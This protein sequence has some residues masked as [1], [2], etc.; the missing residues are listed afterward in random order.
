MK[1]PLPIIVASQF[2][3]TSLWFAGNAVIP[4][5]AKDLHLEDSFVAHITSSVQFGFISGTFIF[6]FLSIADRFSPS[7]VFFIS[8]ILAS[9]FN[10][11]ACLNGIGV[12]SLLVL[13]FLTGFFLAGIY[14]V[15]MKIASDY[16]KGNL[17]RSLGFLLAALVLGTAFPHLLKSLGSSL[18]WK[19]VLASTSLF[20][21]LGGSLLLLLVP[22]G[23]YRVPGSKL[24][25]T[26]FINGFKKKDFRSVSFGYFGHMWELYT[27]WAF[28]PVILSVYNA[29]FPGSDIN[30]PLHSFFIIAVGSIACVISGYLSLSFGAKPVATACLLLSGLCCISSP[31][32]LQRDSESIFL[33]FLYFWGMVVIADS[34]MFST[35]VANSVSGELK[36]SS[37]TIVNCIGFSITII[38]IQFINMATDLIDHRFLFALLAAGPILGLTA[39][40]G[41]FGSTGINRN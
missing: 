5:L 31:F 32:F 35:L 15:G 4:D 39:L 33:G 3:C 41:K 26:D 16:Y 17:G 37:L 8:S 30:V 25:F 6:A 22:D 20:A 12:G 38:S 2:L 19:W 14:P 24:K 23:P 28:I 21:L 9:L 27:F 1:G 36:G 10:L 13:R 7:R 18:P 40:A 29:T 11:A 34:P